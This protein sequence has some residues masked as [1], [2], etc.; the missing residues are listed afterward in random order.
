MRRLLLFACWLLTSTAAAQDVPIFYDYVENGTL[1]GGK[2]VMDRANPEHRRIFGLDPDEG[3]V[4]MVH[5]FTTIRNNGPSSNRI[6]VVLLG[7]GYTPEELNAYA[8]HAGNVNNSFFAQEP[9]AAYSSYF[10]VHRVDVPSI[11]SGV[12]EIDLNIFRNTAL[13]M[14]YGCFN[15]ERLLCISISKAHQAAASAP[16]FEQILALANSTRYGGAGYPADEVGTLAGNNGSAVEIALHEFGHAFADLHDEYDYADGA[17]YFGG[18]F[19]E[20]NVSIFT[21]AELASMGSKWHLW[22]DLP[23]VDSFEGGAYNQFGVYRPTFNSKMRALNRPFEEVNVE[24]LVLSMYEIVSPIDDATA[25]SPTPLSPLTTFYVTPLAPNDHSLSVQWA[26]DGDDVVGATEMTFRLADLSPAPG[27]YNVSVTVTDMTTRVR[28]EAARAAL[29]T[30][31]RQWQVE[32]PDCAIVEAVQAEPAAMAKSRFISFLPGST[33]SRTAIRVKLV[34]LHHP[35][36]EYTAGTASDFTA[37]E[38]EFRWVGPP[39]QFVESSSSTETFHAASL[40]CAPYFMDW[41]TVGTLHVTGPE[42]VP[43]SVYEVWTLLDGCDSAVES[44]FSSSI[45]I[46]TARWGDVE[47]PFNPPAVSAQ[48]D[49]EDIAGLVDKFRSAAGAPI[50]ARALLAGSDASGNINLAPDLSFAHI[51]ACVDAFRGKAYPYAGPEACD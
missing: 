36:P 12:D 16:E 21:A 10:N 42:V 13:N 26:V 27:V 28:D 1:R 41:S 45:S 9:F 31:T 22:L 48:P 40:Q 33:G 8:A 51:S 7:D 15:I 39:S 30:A 34:S 44:N 47:E 46:N 6:D 43:S 17:T 32:V 3:A 4:A 2:A 35:A 14:A 50:K 24:Q 11:E 38:G 23:S 20:A 19:L 25:A 18:E 29:M 49:F 37:F 5:P